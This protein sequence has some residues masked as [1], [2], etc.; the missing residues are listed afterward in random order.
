MLSR[1]LA[2]AAIVCCA[3]LSARAADAPKKVLLVGSPPDA[4]PV[5]THEYL[6]GMAILGKLPQASFRH[7]GHG[8][9]GRGAVEG[10]AGAV[11]AVRLAS[12]CS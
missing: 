10:R 1:F 2:L 3:N 9:D 8:G 7:R 5:G 12:S 11:G 6:P 4:H